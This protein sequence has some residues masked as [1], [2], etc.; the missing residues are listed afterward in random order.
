[1]KE[2]RSRFKCALDYY[3]SNEDKRRKEKMANN[4]RNKKYKDFWNDVN[5]TKKGRVARSTVIDKENNPQ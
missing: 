4:Y 5:L 3:K 1:M 2:A